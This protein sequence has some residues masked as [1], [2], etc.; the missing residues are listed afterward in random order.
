MT[1]AHTAAAS[2]APGLHRA[3]K[4]SR[5]LAACLGIGF[6]A[7][8]LVGIVLV[9]VMLFGATIWPHLLPADAKLAFDSQGISIHSLSLAQKL[10]VLLTFL[11]R[12]GPS[13]AALYFGRRIFL[14]LGRGE[15]F[16]SSIVT[17]M[18]AA[19][20]WMIAAAFARS[21]DRFIFS[22]SLGRG[23][24]GLSFSPEILFFGVCTYVAA[25]VMA[26]ARQLAEDNASIV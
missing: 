2:P 11:L 20:L 14:K 21:V 3:R 13:A 16:T 1:E 26:E 15:V 25:Y 22:L 19:A 9:G 23:P 5:I 8:A 18:R 12:F 4:L 6:C 10:G 17:D 24:H 7:V